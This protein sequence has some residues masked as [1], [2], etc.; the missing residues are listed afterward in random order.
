MDKP[1][2]DKIRQKQVPLYTVMIRDDLERISASLSVLRDNL[3]PVL[4]DNLLSGDSNKE[5]E[6]ELVPFA[7]ELR[8]FHSRM[9]TLLSAVNYMNEALEL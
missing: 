4:R 8:D 1:E 2:E 5:K 7:S 9:E 6:E 3:A